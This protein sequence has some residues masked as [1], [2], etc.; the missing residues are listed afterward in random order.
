MPPR[1]GP[2]EP[3]VLDFNKHFLELSNLHNDELP[4]WMALM[5]VA[6]VPLCLLVSVAMLWLLW[7]IVF[8]GDPRKYIPQQ[9]ICGRS[10]S[11]KAK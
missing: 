2:P 8:V 7:D 3:T 1:P 9:F 5:L 11:G 10:G 6:F 4:R